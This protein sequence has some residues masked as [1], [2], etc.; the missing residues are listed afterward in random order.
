MPSASVGDASHA[1][2]ERGA[3]DLRRH[4]PA[5]ATA[6]TL[7]TALASRSGS[8]VSHS[9]MTMT[10]QPEALKDAAT[11]ASRCWFASNLRIQKSGRVVGVVAYLQPGCLCQKQP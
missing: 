10:F 4:E 5:V 3:R 7:V 11:A 9:Q 1:Y 6:R 8:L 2:D